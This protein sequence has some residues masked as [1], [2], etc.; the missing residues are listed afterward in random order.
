MLKEFEMLGELVSDCKI[1]EPEKPDL[2]HADPRVTYLGTIEDD[3]LKRL[4]TCLFGEDFGDVVEHLGNFVD[5]S[6]PNEEPPPIPIE[7]RR[8]LIKNGLHYAALR[9]AY[10]LAMHLRF[11]TL[12][13]KAKHDMVW[14]TENWKVYLLDRSDK[15]R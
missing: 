11:P 4:Y 2:N 6:K 1:E 3:E 10:E 8:A 9:A 7:K 12:L 5:L 15:R 14:V 13:D